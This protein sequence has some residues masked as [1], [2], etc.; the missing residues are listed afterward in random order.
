MF[1]KTQ[2]DFMKNNGINIDFNKKLSDDDYIE[3]EEKVS[4]L[5]QTIGFNEDYEPTQIG[6]TCEEII[7][8]IE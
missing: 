7:D 6:I 3:I 4:H 1:T 8:A 5:L 2:I